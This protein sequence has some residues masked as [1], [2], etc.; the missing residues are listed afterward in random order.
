MTLTEVLLASVVS[1][2]TVTGLLVLVLK[3]YLGSQIDW[4]FR[5]RE[6]EYESER[7]NRDQVSEHYLHQRLAI[8]PEI[9]QLIYRLRKAVD[10]GMQR[11]H[12]AEWDDEFVT[13]CGE[14][15]DGMFRWEYF[16]PRPLFAQLHEFKRAVQ[17]MLVFYDIRSRPDE[18]SRE[19]AYLEAREQMRPVADDIGRL[20][21]DIAAAIS[22]EA[23]AGR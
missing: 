20:Q 15:T 10:D 1:S 5:R 17:N 19:R 11:P 7:R 21:Q 3:Q 9:S 2:A 23:P 8:Y 4:H 14:L 6:L 22:L 16:L 18:V 13:L 12:I